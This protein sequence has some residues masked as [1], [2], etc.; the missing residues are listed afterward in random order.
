MSL[1]FIKKLG[2][3]GFGI[4]Y[5]AVDQVTGSPMAVKIVLNNK[6]GIRN[7]IEIDTM[8]RIDHP[9][10]ISLTSVLYETNKTILLMP[11]GR[12]LST[13]RPSN[14]RNRIRDLISGVTYLHNH[15]LYH[16]DLKLENMVIIDDKLMLI[17]LGLVN[18]EWSHKLC[19]QSF[20]EA[21]PEHI[22]LVTSRFGEK[23]DK[24]YFAKH[25]NI[26]NQKTNK[27]R[28]DYWA[29]GVCIFKMIA[30][31]DMF[32]PGSNAAFINSMND[33]FDNPEAYIRQFITDETWVPVILS[34][35]QP[36]AS[37]R[38]MIE[39]IA[40][41][42]PLNDGKYIAI[43]RPVITKPEIYDETFEW[44][45]TIVHNKLQYDFDCYIGALDIVLR[46][47]GEGHKHDMKLIAITAIFMMEKMIGEYIADIDEVLDAVQ[48][49][50]QSQLLNAERVIMKSLGNIILPEDILENIDRTRIR[51]YTAGDFIEDYWNT[52]V[53]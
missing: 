15:A 1:K 17:D 49:Y 26:F 3:G 25:K 50:T 23:L 19:T 53:S 37:K 18:G 33:Y 44:L 35:M 36:E 11:V 45:Y 24:T 21:P 20:M 40:V 42:A 51:S 4:V 6:N 27:V 13:V 9:N 10:I 34:L 22:K 32:V 7:L 28:S 48:D 5:E 8:S 39:A 52:L 2:S 29:I 41:V 31:I 12:P 47:F 46:F 16:C 43:T 14:R 38:S 30:G